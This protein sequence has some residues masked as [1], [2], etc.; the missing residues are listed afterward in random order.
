MQ[1]RLKR[2]GNGPKYEVLFSV[3][4]L[5]QF[6]PKSA[7]QVQLLSKDELILITVTAIQLSTLMRG[8]DLAQTASALFYFDDK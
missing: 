7:A 6:V 5:A 3:K 4:P 8:L 1:A 2:Q